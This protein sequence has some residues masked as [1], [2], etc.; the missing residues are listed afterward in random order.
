M[1]TRSSAKFSGLSLLWSSK[2]EGMAQPIPRRINPVNRIAH[3]IETKVDLLRALAVQVVLVVLREH[4]VDRD[5]RYTPHDV[6]G[7]PDALRRTSKVSA[8][9]VMRPSASRGADAVWYWNVISG[10][11]LAVTTCDDSSPKVL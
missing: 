1:S 10:D 11:P 9:S 8:F 5:V 7:V 4:V 2:N 3:R 6:V